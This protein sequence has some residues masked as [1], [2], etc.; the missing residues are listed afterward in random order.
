MVDSV[1]VSPKLRRATDGYMHWCVACEEMHPLPDSWVFDHN[2]EMPTFSPSF[3]HG[4]VDMGQCCHYTL[5]A[6]VLTYH[7][8]CTHA[9]ANAVIALA[10]LP[11]EYQDP[12]IETKD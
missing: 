4:S 3:R 9:M 2:L 7:S 5:T 10:D 8:D 12:P 11:I 6:G 1:Q